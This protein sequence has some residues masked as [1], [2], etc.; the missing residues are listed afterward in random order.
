MKTP[1]YNTLIKLGEYFLAGF[2]ENKFD[3][4]LRR[5]SRALLLYAEHADVGEYDGSALFP[6]GG[7]N[8]WRLIPDSSAGFSYSYTFFY[9]TA[10]FADKIEA[11]PDETSKT[12]MRGVDAEMATM[13]AINIAH[14]YR[15][16]GGGYT[17]S[18]INYARILEEG[19]VGYRRRLRAALASSEEDDEKREFHTSLLLALDAISILRDKHLAKLKSVSNPDAKLRKL[20]TAME[21][22]PENPAES[23]YEAMVATNFMWYVDDGDSIGRLDQFLYPYY[24]TDLETGAI[25]REEAGELLKEFWGSFDARSGWHMVLGGSHD[26]GIA[27]YQDL[28]LLCLKTI[29]KCRRPNTGL[30]VRK[31]M[32]DELWEAVLDSLASGCG[33]PSLYNEEMYAEGIR[34]ILQVDEKD[35]SEFAYGGCTEIMLQGMSN[36]GSIDAGLNL[37]EVLENE[38]PRVAEFNSYD[39]FTEYFLRKIAKVAD[40]TIS[41][42]NLNQKQMELYRPQ[43]IRSLFIEDC[44]DRGIDYN[45]GG[46]R[47]N[48]SVIN[49]VGIANT[50][51][52]LFTIKKIFEGGV[53]PISLKK[54]QQALAA[55]FVGF[56]NELEMIKK[57]DKHGCDNPEINEIA[58]ELSHVVFDEIL[59]RECHRGNGFCAPGTIM[60]ATYAAE[61]ADIGATPDGRRA[62]SP[63]ADSYGPMQGTDVKGPTSTIMSTTCT[64]QYKGLGTL[65]FNLRLD[66]GM[67]E[68]E[69][70]RRKVVSLLKSYMSEGGIMVQVTVA[71]SQ[72]MR[73]AIEHPEKH[74]DLII[75]IGGYSE[76]FN[77]LSPELKQEVIARTCYA[78]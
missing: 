35:A 24:K 74:E 46:A 38:L 58:A 7:A 71:D 12:L 4:Y 70:G 11:L 30:R 66:G 1:T 77:R 3:S 57:L 14:Q 5:F 75:R 18:I 47:Y 72:R 68:N 2:H 16:G 29:Q 55:D 6:S 43:P 32:P 31:D 20:I 26:D 41:Q 15:C 63:V 40:L 52:S 61:G 51:N 59:S 60:F 62:F 23:F 21:K 22:V 78:E 10:L 37:L 42:S 69:S 39:D 64:P 34:N 25:S 56:E 73:D 44:I 9:D 33:H 53:L 27:A 13:G 36:V 54:L 50:I 48:G 65:V 49:V 76:Y 8:I 19:L 17:H 28:T 67:F 45:A